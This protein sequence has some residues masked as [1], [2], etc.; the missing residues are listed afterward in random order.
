MNT[1]ELVPGRKENADEILHHLMIALRPIIDSA[2]GGDV[3]SESVVREVHRLVRPDLYRLPPRVARAMEF[4]RLMAKLSYVVAPIKGASFLRSRSYVGL[5]ED[6]G[7]KRL[8]EYGLAR[9]HIS[10]RKKPFTLHT[11]TISI[12]VERAANEGLSG[13]NQRTIEEDIRLA[14]LYHEKQ[15]RQRRAPDYYMLLSNGES[16]PFYNYSEDWRRRKSYT[17]K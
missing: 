17:A 16:L 6:S 9:Q 1:M 2:I 13:I 14:H 11:L 4:Y 5:T 12:F 15:K 8:K 7:R 10:R 3:A